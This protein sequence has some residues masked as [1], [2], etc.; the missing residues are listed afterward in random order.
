MSTS[1]LPEASMMKQFLVVMG[2]SG[3]ITLSQQGLEP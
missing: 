2:L 3:I 1:T